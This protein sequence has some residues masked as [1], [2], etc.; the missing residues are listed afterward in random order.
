M[1]DL[2]PI[3]SIVELRDGL[4]KFY[5][6]AQPGWRGFVRGHKEDD[7]FKLIY[8]EWDRNYWRF[9][10]TADQADGWTYPAHFEVVGQLKST[11]QQFA[12]DVVAQANEQHTVGDVCKHCGGHHSADG[13]RNSYL[14]AL[15][16]AAEAA[17]QGEGFAVFFVQREE[18]G[19]GVTI[20]PFMISA[21][22]TDEAQ[23]LIEAQIIKVAEGCMDKM[24]QDYLRKFT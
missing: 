19:E 5:N 24:L 9:E 1:S 15:S 10:A 17:A 20:R 12:A 11:P 7:G 6:G 8:V 4:D 2:P 13:Y 23:A 18:D 14:D 22:M 3:G 16:E 21:C